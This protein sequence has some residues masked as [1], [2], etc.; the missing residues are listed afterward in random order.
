[1]KEKEQQ[2]VINLNPIFIS[3]PVDGNLLSFNSI[4]L[5]LFIIFEMIIL[6]LLLYYFFRTELIFLYYNMFK[7]EDYSIEEK[8]NYNEFMFGI[9]NLVT[10]GVFC[11]KNTEDNLWYPLYN[12]KKNMF[13]LDN[14]KLVFDNEK[15][16]QV[17][18]TKI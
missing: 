9:K 2:K 6:C 12:N 11:E 16:C 5:Y 15:D 14:H 1:M 10:S 3:K 8:R 18:L 7:D 17:F 4:F 13:S